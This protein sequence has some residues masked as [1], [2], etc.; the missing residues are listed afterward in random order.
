MNSKLF[1]DLH[2][3]IQLLK[4][5]NKQLK[6]NLEDLNRQYEILEKENESLTDAVHEA[7]H[8]YDLLTNKMKEQKD[9][10]EQ[11]IINTYDFENG[12]PGHEIIFN[13]FTEESLKYFKEFVQIFDLDI[14]V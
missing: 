7:Y 3:Y 10:L 1:K 11:G 8:K 6:F 9:F 2:D 14:E 12:T 4:V 13:T 5:E